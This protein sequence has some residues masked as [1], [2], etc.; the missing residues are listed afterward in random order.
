M[1]S[2]YDAH[3]YCEKMNLSSI[4]KVKDSQRRRRLGNEGRVGRYAKGQA[5]DKVLKFGKRNWRILTL[6]LLLPPVLSIPL[7]FMTSGSARWLLM[8]VFGSMGIWLDVILIILWGGVANQIMGIQGESSTA[9]ILRNFQSKEWFLINGVKTSQYEDIDHVLIGPAGIF[10]FET[11]WSHEAWPMQE[12][13][14]TFMKNRLLKA[15]AQASR[16]K[17]SIEYWFGRDLKGAS[18]R[19][20]CVLWS[21]SEID[22]IVDSFQSEAVVVV[23]GTALKS[24]LA[25]LNERIIAPDQ[26]AR[27][28]EVFDHQV[29]ARDGIDYATV[30]TPRQRV[31][32]FA[33]KSILEPI[34]GFTLA[35][36]SFVLATKSQ[37]LWVDIVEPLIALAIGIVVWRTGRWRGAVVG[38][39]IA[40]LISLI[41]LV[42][43]ALT[44]L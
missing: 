8:G 7:G 40:T 24:W 5:I 17:A 29:K 31:R 1:V 9:N 30:A 2:K 34:F 13:G 26:I 36:Y 44:S 39:L 3:C 38:W 11:K 28:L 25:T 16:N 23:R 43:I 35:A 6:T 27:L 22:G 32:K 37:L 41:F 18:V 21:P 20:V 42:V 12:N 33:R 19:A 14:K 4:E 10:V 15:V